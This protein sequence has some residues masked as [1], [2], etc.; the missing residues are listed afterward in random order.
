MARRWCDGGIRILT[1]M[2]VGLCNRPV[3]ARIGQW[4]RVDREVYAD[5]INMTVC[6]SA[7][8]GNTSLTMSN[9]PCRH[10]KSRAVYNGDDAD[11]LSA[12]L[13]TF[14]AAL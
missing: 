11:G 9:L 3:L 7:H 6:H 1:D 10:R 13:V 4:I 8:D 12:S 2:P 5:S 14:V